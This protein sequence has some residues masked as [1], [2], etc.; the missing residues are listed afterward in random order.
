MGKIYRPLKALRDG[1]N[2][3]VALNVDTALVLLICAVVDDDLKCLR[4][5]QNKREQLA[6]FTSLVPD[7]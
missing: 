3:D 4:I 6:P 1:F 2:L 5:E 7:M